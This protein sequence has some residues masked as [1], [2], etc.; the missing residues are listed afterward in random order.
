MLVLNHYGNWFMSGEMIEFLS[1]DLSLM[2]GVDD[3]YIK[4]PYFPNRLYH[5]IYAA[6]TADTVV[7]NPSL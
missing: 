5:S 2:K 7:A 6:S 4:N 3:R 1:R